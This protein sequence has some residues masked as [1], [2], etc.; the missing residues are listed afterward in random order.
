MDSLV[1]KRKG[2]ETKSKVSKK[3]GKVAGPE[4]CSQISIGAQFVEQRKHL[5]VS[6]TL[7]NRQPA[8]KSGSH[9]WILKRSSTN[10]SQVGHCVN[11][12]CRNLGFHDLTRYNGRPASRDTGLEVKSQC[13]RCARRLLVSRATGRH[14]PTE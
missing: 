3:H 7:R 10:C 1:K 8:H 11:A 13:R 9:G 14:P 2:T 5:A 12:S 4:T 6:L